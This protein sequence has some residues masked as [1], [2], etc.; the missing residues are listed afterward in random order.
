MQDAI[1]LEIADLEIEA[2]GPVEL[3]P[4]VWRIPSPVP[5]GARLVNLYLLRGPSADDWLLVDCP[6]NTSRSEA[7]LTAAL[8]Q[9]GIA[10][11]AISAIVLTHTHPDHLGAAGFWQQRTGARIH[12]LAPAAHDILPLWTD[13]DNKAFIEAARALV[14]HGM[15]ADEAQALVTRAVQIRAVLVP[16]T[17]PTLLAHHQHVHLAG[18]TYRVYWLPGHADGHLGLLRDDGLLLAGDT[19]LATMQPTVGWYPWSRSDPMADQLAT[20][21]ALRSIPARLTLPGHGAPFANLDERANQLTGAYTRELVTVSRL[22]AESAPDGLT[23]YTLAN[24]LY[25]L[26][27]RLPDSRLLAMSESVARLEHLRIIGR[28]ECITGDDGLLTY[29]RSDESASERQPDSEQTDIQD[30]AS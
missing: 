8:A 1:P 25:S 19:V 27:M 6:L 9:I 14:A 26:R 17:R 23:A 16:P 21:T 30:A 13:L 24:T 22:L 2:S 18:A 15:P 20:L 28:A 11:S 7:A 3:E 29:V 5:F 10:P 12:L 4:G